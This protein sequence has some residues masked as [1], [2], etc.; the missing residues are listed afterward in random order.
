MTMAFVNGKQDGAGNTIDVTVNKDR[1]GSSP[2]SSGQHSAD[3]M[4]NIFDLEENYYEY[5]AE[6]GSC[7]TDNPF[8]RR[9]GRSG[10]LYINQA[11][12]RYYDNFSASDYSSFR[13][14]LYVM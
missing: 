13:F 14:V 2:A 7:S 3:R 11:S 9:G 5:V 6:M 10:G 8:A 4:C 12:Y 1:G